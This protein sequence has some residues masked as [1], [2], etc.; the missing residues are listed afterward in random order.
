MNDKLQAS[1]ALNA[2]IPE[3]HP[4]KH[5]QQVIDEGKVHGEPGKQKQNDV[6]VNESEIALEKH[7]DNVNLQ[8]D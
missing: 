4:P 7:K 1:S 8:G 6:V 5:D 3:E 2:G